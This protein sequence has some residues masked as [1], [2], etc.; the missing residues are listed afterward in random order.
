MAETISRE[1]FSIDTEHQLKDCGSKKGTFILIHRNEAKF[2][3]VGDS[4]LLNTFPITVNSINK[5]NQKI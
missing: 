2:L 4:F 1:H 5:I 3:Q